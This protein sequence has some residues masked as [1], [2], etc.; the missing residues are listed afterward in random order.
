V[1]GNIKVKLIEIDIGVLLIDFFKLLFFLIKR[2][3]VLIFFK[4]FYS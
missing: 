1:E 4:E 3:C 2:E